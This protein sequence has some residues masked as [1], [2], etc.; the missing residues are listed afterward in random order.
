MDS[1]ILLIDCHDEVGLVHRVTGALY[2]RNCN[3][4]RNGEFVD[5]ESGHFF[6]RTEFSG[7]VE[8]REI[9]DELKHILPNGTT[10]RLTQNS[11]KNIIIM[12]TTEHHCLGDLLLR[13]YYDELNAN[14]LA[15]ISN[16]NR[17]SGL[18]EKF[19]VP[20]HYI[21]HEK[22]SRPAHEEKILAIID[23]LGSEYIV[24]AR[25]MRILSRHFVNMFPNRM[26]NIHHSF[27]PAFVGAN[28]YKKAYERGVKI[29]GATSHFVTDNLDEGPIIAQSIA[30]VDHTRSVEDMINAGRDIERVVLAQSLK[31]VFEERVFVHN[32]KTIIFD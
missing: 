21:S 1:H 22:L 27:L 20:F 17:L 6:M 16:H 8:E 23:T 2:R 5:R 13:H 29:I 3:I 15:V 30:P 25:Y 9:S 12:A 7:A 28:P 19:N 4:I 11:K 24:L 18:A 14:I 26:I 31:L 10:I 32:N